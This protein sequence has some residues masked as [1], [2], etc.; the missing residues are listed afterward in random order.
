MDIHGK[1]TLLGVIDNMWNGRW[2][3]PTQ[4]VAARPEHCSSLRG[5]Q[6][7]GQSVTPGQQGGEAL[8]KYNINTGLCKLVPTLH[9]PASFQ[10]D[11]DE[12]V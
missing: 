8:G 5:Q 2:L 9:P 7:A 1:I 4:A 6:E 11:P 3:H 12:I 10:Y